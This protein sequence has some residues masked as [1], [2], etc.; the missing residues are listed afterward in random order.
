MLAESASLH[1]SLARSF[2][3]SVIH[4]TFRRS[5]LRLGRES[6]SLFGRGTHGS[7]ARSLAARPSS[8]APPF[9]SLLP[10]CASRFPPLSRPPR[11][12]PVLPRVSSSQSR[13]AKTH[14]RMLTAMVVTCV[15][16]GTAF[17]S[18]A[19][20]ICGLIYI[21][22]TTVDFNIFLPLPEYSK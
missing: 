20:A 22:S 7:L 5:C 18:A 1:G 4:S 21:A 15:V 11:P 6:R 19:S 13:S 2:A 9:L 14:S 16:H 3:R 8:R 12:P 17:E 10:P